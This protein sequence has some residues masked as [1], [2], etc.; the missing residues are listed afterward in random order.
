MSGSSALLWPDVRGLRP[1]A[2]LM[3]SKRTLRAVMPPDTLLLWHAD[4]FCWRS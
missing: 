2:C 4:R 1:C 3:I